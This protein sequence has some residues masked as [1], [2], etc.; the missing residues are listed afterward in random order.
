MSDDAYIKRERQKAKKLRK[1]VWWQQKV[2][3]EGKC[4]YC[5]IALDIKSATM[6]HVIPISK[7]GGSTKGNLVVCCKKCNVDKR[8]KS[9]VELLLEGGL[10]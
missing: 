2:A 6:D 9:A 7:G 1:S 10:S 8:S 5:A 3:R 4:Y